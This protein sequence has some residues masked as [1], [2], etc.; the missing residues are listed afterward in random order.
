[1]AGNG[2]SLNIK[3]VRELVAA[4]GG[5]WQPSSTELWRLPLAKKRLR[6]GAVPP[7]TT[8]VAREELARRRIATE[9]A[10][11][12]AY[13]VSHD[14]RS[15]GGLSYVTGIRDQG[16]CGSCVAFG[17]AATVETTARVLFGAA[18][19]I[20]ISEAQLFYCVAKDKGS[21]CET[22]WWPD[23]AFA[24]FERMGIT[25]EAHF[26]YTA[27]DRN[28]GLSSGWQNVVSKLTGWHPITSTAEMKAWLSTRGALSACFTVYED[29]YAYGSGV[30]THHTGAEVGG[31]CVSVVGYD[32]TQKCWICKN[33]WGSG[34]GEAGFFR[35]GYGQCGIEAEMWAADGV[36]VPSANTVPLYRYWNSSTFDHFYTTS[37]AELGNGK[38][39]YRW[40]ETQCYVFA[41]QQPGSVPL[42]RYWNSKLGD[43]FY[44]TNWAELGA[45]RAGY[46][47]E[48]IQCYVFPAAGHKN[49]ALYRYWNATGGDHFYTT[50]Y[51][52]L[53]S[54]GHGYHL[55]MTQAFVP[56]GPAATAAT[57][58]VDA[59]P[60][61][62]R[63]GEVSTPRASRAGAPA[64]F[65][66]DQDVRQE[67]F[68]RQ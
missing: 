32:D 30:Y 57:P 50:N 41:T 44:T 23:E 7:G 33:S 20:D 52:E 2:G 16:G 24:A 39:G 65:T 47:Y 64:T 66:V 67:A 29:F 34:W 35:I 1:M 51:D 19:A 21:T 59:V 26:A 9:A 3:K 11:P 31:H 28:C 43:H 53:R 10:A 8:M 5:D 22:G 48:G 63:A 36:I 49:A 14:W 13:P 55:E 45:G 60:E 15:V 27:G 54:E 68:Q 58:E 4:G 12:G 6:L 61:S 37:W 25:D 40:E 42:Y 62:F 18:L 56:A 17:T 46:A 38:Y